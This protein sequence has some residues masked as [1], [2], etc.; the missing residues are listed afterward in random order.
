[1]MRYVWV[2]AA[3]LALGA[4]I[5]IWRSSTPTRKSKG[6]VAS[7]PVKPTAT[8]AAGEAK[9]DLPPGH[10]GSEACARCHP[11]AHGEWKASAHF[12]NAGRPTPEMVVGDFEKNNTYEFA[13]TRSRMFRRGDDYMM[14]YTE[15]DGETWTHKIAWA[16]GIMRHQVYLYEAPDGRLQVMPTYWNVEEQHW[17]DALEGS[18]QGPKPLPKTHPGH[19]SNYM[20]TWNLACMECHA[21]QGRK[22]YDPKTNTYDVRF[23]PTINCE[24]CH[25][26]GQAHVDRWDIDKTTS[27]ADIPDPIERLNDYD[28]E[29]SVEVCAMCHAAKKVYALGYVPGENFYDYFVPDV[30]SPGRFFADGRSS[31]LNYRWVGFWQNRCTPNSKARL[32]CGYCHPPHSLESVRDK[33]VA[34]SNEICTRCHVDIKTKLALHT[35]HSPESE[36]SMCVECHMPKMPLNMHMTVR[37]HTMGSPLPELTEKYQAPNACSGCHDET[38]AENLRRTP[39]QLQA[40]VDA[41]FGASAHYQGYRERMGKRADVLTAVFSKSAPMPWTDLIAWLDDPKGSLVQRASAAQMLGVR[42]KELPKLSSDLRG[43][44]EKALLRHARNEHPLIRYFSVR[45]L[46]SMRSTN[47]RLAVRRALADKR[48]VVRMQ[49]ID[50]LLGMGESREALEESRN[51]VVV[52]AIGEYRNWED[53]VRRDDPR[54]RTRAARRAWRKGDLE[55]AERLMKE[56]AALMPRDIEALIELGALLLRREKAGEA[57]SIAARAHDLDP[58]NATAGAVYANALTAQGN[59]RGAVKVLNTVAAKGEMPMELMMLHQKLRQRLA[60]EGMGR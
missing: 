46:G 18:V 13:G 45:S 58:G 6:T 42:P 8:V 12:F 2:G 3:L 38:A 1:M 37:D 20:R 21:S 30:W 41:W 16:S 39:K 24:S 15:P 9:P 51:P 28:L 19:W 40:D 25:G 48:L 32:D 54:T 7:T 60:I 57:L 44:I 11:E 23:D 10:T 4:G 59:I 43:D 53:D 33:N 56:R 14:E 27:S 49:A 26:P 35:H 52:R 47:A 22:Y 31:S 36:G 5:W 29:R 34:Q 50:A 55:M 17:R